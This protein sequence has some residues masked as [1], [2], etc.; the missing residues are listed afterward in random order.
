MK[1][2]HCLCFQK[3]I[4]FVWILTFFLKSLSKAFMYS[5]QLSCSS[6]EIPKNLIDCDLFISHS[7]IFEQFI[8][9][10]FYLL[11]QSILNK[12]SISEQILQTY[13]WRLPWFIF[14]KTLAHSEVLLLGV[15]VKNSIKFIN[16]VAKDFVPCNTLIVN[17]MTYLL[18]CLQSNARNRGGFRGGHLVTCHPLFS[19]M[20]LQSQIL[21][22]EPFFLRL[23]KFVRKYFLPRQ[24]SRMY[25]SCCNLATSSIQ[26][27]DN[28]FQE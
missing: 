5:V 26:F 21:V 1:N 6:T 3:W 7:L 12:S 24:F 4:V 25:S 15:I 19:D 23:S 18:Q 10:I 17:N 27:N 28:I 9:V 22:T 13:Y 14:N 11:D 20:T 2:F 16:D 8:S